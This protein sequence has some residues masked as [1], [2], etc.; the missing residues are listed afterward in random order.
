MLG[1]HI[2]DTKISNASLASPSRMHSLHRWT[3]DS[4]WAPSIRFPRT[5]IVHM[6]WDRVKNAKMSARVSGGRPSKTSR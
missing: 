3:P 2:P 1:G 6:A 4:T 5:G